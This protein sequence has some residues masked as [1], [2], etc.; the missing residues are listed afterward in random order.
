[1]ST[2]AVENGRTKQRGL[3]ETS[4]ATGQSA[5]ALQRRRLAVLKEAFGVDAHKGAARQQ[6]SP[7][8]RFL[9]DLKKAKTANITPHRFNRK[10]R[11]SKGLADGVKSFAMSGALSARSHPDRRLV[12]WH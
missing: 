6:T 8:L 1:M 3:L 7:R 11:E 2:R 10:V 4:P 5:R 9:V 12:S